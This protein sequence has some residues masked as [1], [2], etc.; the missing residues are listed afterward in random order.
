M[1]SGETPASASAFA[2]AFAIAFALASEIGQGFSLGILDRV[3]FGS[4]VYTDGWQGYIGLDG[5]GFPNPHSRS[6]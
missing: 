5:K 3:G 4:T 2:F 6:V 1:R